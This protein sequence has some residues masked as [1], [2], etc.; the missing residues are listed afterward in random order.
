[1][2]MGKWDKTEGNQGSSAPA[3]VLDDAINCLETGAATDI[4]Y[5]AKQYGDTETEKQIKD[6]QNTMYWMCDKAKEMAKVLRRLV[7]TPDLN[8]ESLED[9]TIDALH[10]AQTLL[11]ELNT[12]AG[13]REQSEEESQSMRI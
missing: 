5:D 12:P 10:E 2:V 9:E 4:W 3:S 13:I 7:N 11:E 1:M 8:L 6:V